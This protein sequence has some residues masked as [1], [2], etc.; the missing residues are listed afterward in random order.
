MV[1][2]KCDNFTKARVSLT[3][4][5]FIEKLKA[6]K[7]SYD[8]VLFDAPSIDKNEDGIALA[9][10]YKQIALVVGARTPRKALKDAIDKINIAKINLLGIIIN[11]K[12]KRNI[13]Q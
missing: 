13:Y 12:N 5:S 2:S 1:N 10:C 9:K 6:V 11:K 4:G 3:N 8:I 7:D